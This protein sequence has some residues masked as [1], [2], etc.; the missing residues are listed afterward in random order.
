MPESDAPPPVDRW[1]L[2]DRRTGRMSLATRAVLGMFAHS[3]PGTELYLYKIYTLTLW[4]NGTISRVLHRLTAAGLLVTRTE[5]GPGSNGTRTRT[6]YTMPAA[7]VAVAI[8]VLDEA[9]R[10]PDD[11]LPGVTVTP[12]IHRIVRALLAVPR[13]GMTTTGVMAA[14]DLAPSTARRVLRRLRDVGHV[15]GFVD[16]HGS[17]RWLLHAA[18]LTTI[19]A[20]AQFWTEHEDTGGN[21]HSG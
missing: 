18:T 17:Q 21:V 16:R 4:D 13:T 7:C 3:D 15:V 12:P 1:M 11:P 8:D 2:A 6:Y 10:M 19:Q 14:T 20:A 9:A 5:V